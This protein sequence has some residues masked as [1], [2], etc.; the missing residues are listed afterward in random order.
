MLWDSAFKAFKT[1]RNWG[2][3]IKG[4]GG[5]Q[6]VNEGIKPASRTWFGRNWNTLQQARYES[7]RLYLVLQVGMDPNGEG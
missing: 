7:I 6:S 5:Q 3:L 2:F 4:T 1:S